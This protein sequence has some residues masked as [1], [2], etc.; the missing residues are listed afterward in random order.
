M[1]SAN[2]YPKKSESGFEQSAIAN[3]PCS[4]GYTISTNGNCVKSVTIA[5][6]QGND[7]TDLFPTEETPDKTEPKPLNLTKNEGPKEPNSVSK[8]QPFLNV[9]SLFLAFLILAN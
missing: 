8:I 1:K 3:N 6:D 2:G 7:Y 9:C 4:A 5:N